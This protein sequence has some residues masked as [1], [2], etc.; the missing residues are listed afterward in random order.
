MKSW[1]EILQIMAGRRSSD[2]ILKQHMQ[3]V[4]AY[5]NSDYAIPLPDVKGQPEMR[6]L[7]PALVSQAIDVRATQAASVM[8]SVYCPASDGRSTRSV[9]RAALK[10]RGIEAMWFD[11]RMKLILRRYFRHLTGYASGAMVV[12]P[13]Y[14]KSLARVH[15]RDP[16]TA[17]PE[18]RAAEDV[19]P[20]CDCG[21]V[22]L[23]SP[24][25]CM[26][27]YPKDANGLD[28]RNVWIQ[29]ERAGRLIEVVE[30]IDDEQI[31]MGTTGH[32]DNRYA[33]FYVEDT[34]TQATL[35]STVVNKVGCAPIAV[36][37]AVTLDR[38]QSQISKLLPMVDWMEQ[39][40][41]LETIAAEKGVFPDMYATGVN[42]TM[43]Q[44][45]GPWQ[46]GRTGQINLL[47]G[48]E[49]RQLTQSIGPATQQ[50]LSNLERN[51]RVSM[52]MSS[53]QSGESSGSI[54]SGQTVNALLGASADP[55]T[56]EMHEIAEVQL[57]IIS[58]HLVNT[59]K[60][61]FGSKQISMY[62]GKVGDQATVDFTANTDFEND[63]CSVRYAFPGAS[64]SEITVNLAQLL[65]ANMMS[66]RDAM[67]VHPLID[68]PDAELAQMQ[69]E[70]VT[71]AVV[72]AF[73]QQL[74]GGQA[75]L[76]DGVF[77]LDRVMKGDGIVQAIQAAHDAAQKRQA[78]EAAPPGPG[79]AVPPETMP[80]LSQPGMGVESQPAPTIGPP[81]ESLQNLEGL[82]H[83]LKQ[84]PPIPQGAA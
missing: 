43:P 47:A 6:A 78:A 20:P 61:C 56:M 12:E 53:L 75:P 67:M 64:Q 81:P 44:L 58:K 18:P 57:E 46:D 80:G 55:V 10:R 68:D 15:L 79:M 34:P 52:G 73:T 31:A 48:G 35:L 16:L 25:W 26:A 51:F 62:S 77:V 19:T 60:K 27:M 42:G 71:D 74:A 50:V 76:A 63:S 14:E 54:R 5:Y 3:A 22:Y 59:Q 23:K 65:G 66:R 13:D 4:R 69:I 2:S 70:R 32:F 45:Q 24:A 84:A 82:F 38:T 83:A 39:I 9:Q 40:S 30:W 11:S 21:F 7:A 49:V 17:Y 8:P 36:G 33:T 41:S 28:M 1:D 72:G 37:R 29:A